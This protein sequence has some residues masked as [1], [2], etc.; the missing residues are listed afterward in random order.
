MSY[1]ELKSSALDYE[2]VIRKIFLS[3]Y[4]EAKALIMSGVAHLSET[5]DPHDV[6]ATQVVLGNLFNYPIASER[7]A[8]ETPSASEYADLRSAIAYFAKEYGANAA[9]AVPVPVTPIGGEEAPNVTPTLSAGSYSDKWGELRKHREF[10]V[11]QTGGDWENPVWQGTSTTDSVIVG[12]VLDPSENYEWRCR[13]VPLHG[14]PSYW[15]LPESFTVAQSSVATPTLSFTPLLGNSP[16]TGWPGQVVYVSGDHYAIDGTF[17]IG[18]PFDAGASGDTHAA[19]SWWVK[20]SDGF[21]QIV[22]VDNDYDT[23]NLTS[24]EL[25][26]HLFNNRADF[27]RQMVE[28]KMQYISATGARGQVVTQSI[29]R[30]AAFLNIEDITVDNVDG[31]VPTKPTYRFPTLTP[32]GLDTSVGLVEVNGGS[33]T[34]QR[35][36][37]TAESDLSLGEQALECW[38]YDDHPDSSFSARFRCGRLIGDFVVQ[39]NTSFLQTSYSSGDGVLS[40][41]MSLAVDGSHLYTAY[42]HGVIRKL[43]KDGSVVWS[44]LVA[45]DASTTISIASIEIVGGHLFVT[46]RTTG[47]GSVDRAFI[48]SFT[49]DGVERWVKHQ[50][51]ESLIRGSVTDGTYL[52]V[53]GRIAGSALNA[54]AAADGFHNWISKLD[55]NGNVILDHTDNYTY[56]DGSAGTDVEMEYENITLRGADL[57]ALGW[58][59]V[60]S[61]ETELHQLV[62][63]DDFSFKDLYR[64]P[65]FVGA[66]HRDNGFPLTTLANQE[67][68][69]GGDARGSTNQTWVRNTTP[70][71]GWICGYNVPGS[72]KINALVADDTHFYMISPGNTVSKCSLTDGAVV[73]SRKFTYGLAVVLKDIHVDGDDLFISGHQV[74]HQ[75]SPGTKAVLIRMGKDGSVST[76]TNHPD[77]SIDETAIPYDTAY[78]PGLSTNVNLVGN[79]SLRLNPGLGFT[80]LVVTV[81][82]DPNTQVRSEI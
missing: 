50:T 30:V 73:W 29:E 40:D 10:V 56:S 53:C 6:T 81:S 5:N 7:S 61:G 76:P 82:D 33:F 41:Q 36:E 37:Y 78:T 65:P 71:G 25:P 49:S 75:G 57:V 67:Q 60:S 27:N 55:I 4:D 38:A 8:V 21:S 19:T 1:E 42:R 72:G 52:Y 18:S 68:L 66:Y 31:V 54:T 23:E 43:N 44:K 58:C 79:N 2:L 74:H 48:A 46:G 28:V 80:D 64:F 17:A 11:I 59:T 39:A 69:I 45:I 9:V 24:L 16:P 3:R 63:N 51:E 35:A 14:F 20:A 77:Y 26:R 34:G 13:D 32:Y 47:N 22:L 12:E 62:L 15:S 70:F